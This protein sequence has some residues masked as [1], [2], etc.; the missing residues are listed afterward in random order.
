[1]K[2]KRLQHLQ[3]TLEANVRRISDSRVGKLQRILVEGPSRNSA[4]G[5]AGSSATE[6]MGRTECNRIVNFEGGP[7]GA[8]LHGQM[9]QVR[10][11]EALPHSLRG[12]LLV[13]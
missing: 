2:L 12:E 13:T 7:Q 5:K 4:T 11:T 9:L 8:R 10:I 3:A 1:V 6:L